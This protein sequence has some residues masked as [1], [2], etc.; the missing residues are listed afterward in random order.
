[1]K[2]GIF[3]FRRD[4]R[5]YDNQ[6]LIKLSQEVDIIIPIFIFDPNQ[7]TVN[8]KNKDHFSNNALRF[9]CE[10]VDDLN[11]YLDGHLNIFYGDYSTIITNIIKHFKNEE[12]VFGFNEDFTLYSIKRDNE[13]KKL[14]EKND[15]PCMSCDYDFTMASMEHLIKKDGEPFKQY[16]AFRKNLLSQKKNFTEVSHKKIKFVNKKLNLSKMIT[17]EKMHKLYKTDKNYEPVE[18]GSREDALKI[19]KS[20]K[21]FDEYNKDRDLLSYD[22]LRISAHLNFGVIS[23]REL[24]EAVVKHLG[25][26]SLLIN[27]IIW[28]DYYLCLLR[29]LEGANSYED[30]I[31]ERYNKLNW[32]DYHSKTKFKN[33][34]HKRSYDE[35]K[36]MMESQTGFLL[37][38][39][40]MNEIKTT[41]YMHNR[42]RLIVGYFATKYLMINPLAPYI[43]LQSWFS[44]H[45]VDCITSQNKL[46][47]Q[48]LTE[49]DFSGKKFSKKKIDGRPMSVSNTMIKKYDPE[50]EYIKKWLPHLKDVD[51]K[52]LIKW[53]TNFDDKLHP[54]PLFDS[55]ER[56]Q[57]WIK[58][59]G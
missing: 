19:L 17:I 27:Q 26:K 2:Y 46:N 38:D 59:C 56:Y 36:V 6:G 23:E 42:G 54:G 10:C 25:N 58:L 16:G 13:I 41:G 12:I 57:E 29:Y 3:I 43:G 44:R 28:R 7:C 22:T 8:S 32:L 33:K 11:E 52:T 20:L 37:V 5:I 47:C 40:C 34:I 1:M 9:I 51:I 35:W 45:L 14:L 53:D 21:D 15:I 50:C 39:A 24:Y 4:M 49:L 30:H 18:V 31:D 55:K 48:F